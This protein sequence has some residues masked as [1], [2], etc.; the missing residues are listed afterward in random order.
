M[1][2]SARIENSKD[3]HQVTLQ[4]DENILSVVLSQIEVIST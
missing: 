2:F 1:K 3:N 4:T